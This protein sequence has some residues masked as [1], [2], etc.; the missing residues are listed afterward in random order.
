[1]NKNWPS[2]RLPGGDEPR[3]VSHDA[4]CG[5]GS[6]RDAC[7]AFLNIIDNDG[8][9]PGSQNEFAHDR[10]FPFMDFSVA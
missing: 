5:M 3:A 4:R 2:S 10:T 9:P 7:N 6:A 1:M 8:G